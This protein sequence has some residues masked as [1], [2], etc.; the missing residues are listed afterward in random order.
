MRLK[1]GAGCLLLLGFALGL[2]GCAAEPGK[3]SVGR[4]LASLAFGPRMMCGPMPE[5][6]SDLGY[7]QHMELLVGQTSDQLTATMGEPDKIL[8]LSD[9]R[10]LWVYRKVYK[11]H[12]DAE[13]GTE[14]RASTEIYKDSSGKTVQND[15]TISTPYSKPELSWSN[16]CETRFVIGDSGKVERFSFDGA[17]C[18]AAEL[19]QKKPV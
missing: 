10:K 11:G 1:F 7:H 16:Y 8:T 19:P 15:T 13:S 12:E 9:G 5:T 6:Y 4:C 18:R 3:V 17:S 2:S 14:T